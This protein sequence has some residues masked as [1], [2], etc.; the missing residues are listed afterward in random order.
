MVAR[1]IAA[2][3]ER[4]ATTLAAV[5]LALVACVTAASVILRAMGLNLPDAMDF[6]SL[7]MAVAV[8][9]GMVGAVMHGELISVEFFY[10]ALQNRGRRLLGLLSG[11]IS[12]LFLATMAYT[13]IDQAIRV[14]NSGEVTP[15]LRVPLWPL[16]G[17]ALLGL[18]AVAAAAL[19]VWL[20]PYVTKDGGPG[21]G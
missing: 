16:L 19:L 5:S 10:Q 12:F 21:N 9:W 8:F 11:G 7:F 6:A 18:V 20:Q 1:S 17:L 13:G 3:V 4:A 2:R 15:E 14:M